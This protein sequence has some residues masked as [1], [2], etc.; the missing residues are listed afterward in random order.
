M[1]FD[2]I[3][4]DETSRLTKK[5]PRTK[6]FAHQSSIQTIPGGDEKEMLQRLEATH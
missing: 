6:K 3:P 4:K 1:M 2:T 5:A